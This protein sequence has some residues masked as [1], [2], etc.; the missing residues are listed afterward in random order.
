MKKYKVEF[1]F[2]LDENESIVPATEYIKYALEEWD[3]PMNIDIN[4]LKVEEKMTII[5]VS[6]NLE[7]D[8]SFD[9]SGVLNDVKNLMEELIPNGLDMAGSQYSL[10]KDS[11]EVL[12]I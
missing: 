12:C 7:L 5:N 3:T 8:S 9:T 1:I 4:T 2:E 11:I 10:M 6:F